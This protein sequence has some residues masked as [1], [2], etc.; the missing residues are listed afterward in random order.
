VVRFETRALDSGHV[1]KTAGLNRS[2]LGETL[3]E[4][5]AT[6]WRP[7]V[8][9]NVSVLR[10]NYLQAPNPVLGVRAVITSAGV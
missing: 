9:K 5:E 6:G 2:I 4:V 1:R 3:Q 8:P 10:A 7:R